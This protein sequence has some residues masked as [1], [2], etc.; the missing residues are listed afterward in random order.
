[1]TPAEQR[2]AHRESCHAALSAPRRPFEA[3]RVRYDWAASL[4]HRWGL[5]NDET[6]V[7]IGAGRTELDYVLRTDLD[8][9]GQYVPVDGTIDGTDLR[10]WRPSHPADWFVLLEIIEHLPRHNWQPLV[11]ACQKMARR[12]VLISTPNP[13]VVDVLAMDETHVCA[14][15]PSE[16]NELGFRI[17]PRNFY[18]T[19]EDALA[20]QWVSTRRRP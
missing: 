9:R 2:D 10:R 4:M 5:S 16:L 6:V 19:D 7:D 15:Q 3:R 12:G 20:G 17:E 14:V 18:G 1:M 11:T 13:M 8:W